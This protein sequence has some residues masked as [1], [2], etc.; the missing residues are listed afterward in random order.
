MYIIKK[1]FS[2][3]IFITI[4]LLLVQIVWTTLFFL[5]LTK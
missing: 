1:L 5:R 2:G 4:V 3:R